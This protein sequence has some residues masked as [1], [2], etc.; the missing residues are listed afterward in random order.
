VKRHAKA[1]SVGSIEGGGNRRRLG[2]VL[3]VLALAVCALALTAAPAFAATPAAKI[4]TASNVL[5]SSVHVTGEVNSGGG[6]FYYFQY[7]TDDVHWVGNYVLYTPSTE[8]EPVSMDFTGLKASTKYYVRIVVTNLS[9]Q[10]ATSPAPDLEF[11]TLAV[12]AP[13]VLAAGSSEVLYNTAKASGEV[14][15]PSPGNPDPAFDVSC[16]FE[17]ITDANFAARD[18]KQSLAI[19]ATGGTF[20]LSFGDPAQTTAPIARGASAASVQAALEALADIGPGNVTVSGGPNT[21][22]I[23]FGGSLA[24]ENVAQIGADGSGL[25]GAEASATTEVVTQGHAEGFEG[26]S[27]RPCK[28]N[29]VTAADGP[30]VEAELTDLPNGTSFHL[31]LAAT[32]AGGTDF[33]DGGTFTTLLV[34]PPT[35]EVEDATAVAGTTAHFSG[36]VTAGGTNQAFDTNCAFDYVTAA[37]FEVN[38]FASAQSV[39][40]VPNPVKG[41][42]STAVAADPTNLIPHTTYHLRLRAQNKNADGPVTDVAA[43]FETEPISPPISGTAAHEI[44]T[45]SATLT[46][47]VN[48]GGAATTYH[49]EYLSEDDYQAAGEQFT[50]AHST[51]ESVPFAADN[52]DHPAAA[53]IA[54]LAADTAY[55]FRVVATN[56]KS[57]PGGENGPARTFRTASGP[58]GDPCSN[59]AVRAQQESTYLRECR[60]FEIVSPIEKGASEA[61]V[62]TGSPRY[63]VAAAD[64]SALFY[65]EFGPIETASRGLQQYALGRRGPDG[66]TSSVPIPAGTPA[67]REISAIK[68]QVSG[69][70]VSGDRSRVAFTSLDSRLPDVPEDP[71]HNAAALYL[72]NTD[73]SLEWL[74]R[75]LVPNSTPA[76][77]TTMGAPWLA[78]VGGTPDL[79][80]VYFWAKPNLLPEDQAR[81]D[82]GLEGF[83]LYEYTNGVLK[84][85]G[86]LP[87]GTEPPGGSA[88]ANQGSVAAHNSFLLSNPDAIRNQVSRDGSTLIFVTPDPYSPS[89]PGDVID[90]TELYV[91]HGGHSTLVSH[92]ADGTQAPNGITALAKTTHGSQRFA[93]LTPDGKAVFFVSA[94]SLA[95]GAPNDSSRK[96][97]RYD[98]E[99]DTV[100]YLPGVANPLISSD[101]GQR[102]LFSG[103]PSGAGVWDHGTVRSIGTVRGEEFDDSG[104]SLGDA[105]N[106]SV[107]RATA[108]GSA[109]VFSTKSSIDGANTGA[110][111]EQ[112]Y[113]YDLA[114]G[115]TICLSCPPD[116]IEPADSA[117][118]GHFEN[119]DEVVANRGISTD[120]SLVFFDSPDPLLP[121]DV[122]GKSDVYEWAAGR[123]S[124]VSSGHG[125]EGAF[126]LDN[127]ASGD[128]VFVATADGL[129][130]ADKDGLG[131]VYDARVGGGSLEPVFNPCVGEACRGGASARPGAATSATSSFSGPGNKAAGGK[132]RSAAGS[133]VKVGARR[134]VGNRVKLTL[135]VPAPGK[136]AVSGAGLRTTRHAYAKAGRYRLEVPLSAGAKSSLQSRKPL[137]L[138]VH[139]RFSPKSGRPSSVNFVLT[140]KA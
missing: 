69:L 126:F 25:S 105:I 43:N 44:T 72:S 50:G 127:S 98:V 102:L 22:T 89:E 81:M 18:E 42:G 114:K 104:T 108:S 34:T 41:T 138:K 132:R 28:D 26:A 47:R 8:F 46:A 88:A 57:P 58:S 32:N 7:S 91:R 103:G 134:L 17:Y 53:P 125:K 49:F 19:K 106:G 63:A 16:N 30:A 24:G 136:V 112:I 55:R 113:R 70:L 65:G 1:P 92:A 130:A 66:W 29:P 140:A 15:R 40:C 100:T 75:P 90:P 110:D 51:P 59:A 116:D 137:K 122:N 86:T 61:G 56:L 73:G 139:L 94:D 60:A 31:R 52:N 20:T 107:A 12:P 111:T 123:L 2:S 78:A 54:G 119:D 64:G 13:T 85:A 128:D 3:A 48:S 79:S 109:F 124:L 9:G 87:D 97:Y 38:G 83:G 120:G 23:L 76:P 67:E 27:S 118:M 74:S 62:A 4:G 14:E 33:K 36:Q 39:P 121:A 11:T 131:D 117:T 135:T 68:Y 115:K 95:A 93:L 45:A 129:V 10:E 77:G 21:Y 6:G 71:E 35:V 80:T 82:S 37:Q 5:G 101:D 133:K 99:T 84:T 96:T